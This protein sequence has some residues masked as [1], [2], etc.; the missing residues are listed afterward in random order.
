MANYMMPAYSLIT[1]RPAFGKSMIPADRCGTQRLIEARS[2][3]KKALNYLNK[4]NSIDH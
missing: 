4:I 3:D 1:K 2:V